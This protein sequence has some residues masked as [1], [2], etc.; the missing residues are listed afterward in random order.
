MCALVA[1]SCLTVCDPMDY[2][3][4][5]PSVHGLSP[6]KNIAV[7]CHALL[8]GHVSEI[9]PGFPALQV[10]PLPSEPPREAPC[11]EGG[12]SDSSEGLLQRQ[13]GRSVNL[14][15]EEHSTC[16]QAH[17]FYRRLLLVPRN[18]HQLEEF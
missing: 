7:G 11:P 10:Y 3:L 12:T 2:S 9:E 15:K 5:G 4:P 17:I 18:R 16:T 8:Q 6:G 1:R 13:G 14:V